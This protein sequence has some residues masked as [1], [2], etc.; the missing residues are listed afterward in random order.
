[1][2]TRAAT[3]AA[4]LNYIEILLW[5]HPEGLRPADI[6]R[7]LGVHRST[8]SRYLCDL[9]DYIY[10]DDDGKWKI[11]EFADLFRLTLNIHEA[12]ALHL[13]ARMMTART[14]KINP[15]A[16]ALLRKL[17]LALEKSAPAMA[18]HILR[19]ADQL[20][21]SSRKFEPAYVENLQKLTMAWVT[22]KVVK[23]QHRH[24]ESGQV[25]EYRFAPYFIEPYPLGRTTHVIG[26]RRPPGALR[27]FK[28]ERIVTVEITRE[29]YEIPEDFD[30]YELLQHAWGI[31]YAEGE[32]AEIVLRFT[33]E[34]APRVR[35]TRW[36]PTEVIETCEDGSLMWKARVADPVE[37]LPW[38][39]GWGKDVEVLA[40][41]FLR[42]RIREEVRS[43]AA[44][45]LSGDSGG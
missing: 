30:P 27:T 12:L 19:A 34:V 43:L 3:K 33:P 23:V 8:V 7:R 39:R 44:R 24:I 41:A 21:D 15:H 29:A 13:A 9:P 10:V 1:M 37:M 2:H 26:W 11:S 6:A 17:G 32:P 38:I 20:D 14:D 42:T 18:R 36:H 40:P 22:R 25:Y 45:Y 5:S 31:M 16:A 4:R 28:I 35:E